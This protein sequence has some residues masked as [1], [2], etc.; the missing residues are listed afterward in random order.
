MRAPYIITHKYGTIAPGTDI[1]PHLTDSDVKLLYEKWSPDWETPKEFSGGVKSI[2]CEM[3][4]EI[5][6]PD[7]C[8]VYG[9]KAGERIYKVAK[10]NA[11]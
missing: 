4:V 2:T 7:F 3:I 5:S 11:G 10:E 8:K 6:L 1:D 9:K